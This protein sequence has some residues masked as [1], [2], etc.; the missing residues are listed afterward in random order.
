M[1]KKP[2]YR[3]LTDRVKSDRRLLEYLISYLSHT[4][5]VDIPAWDI[6]MKEELSLP[7]KRAPQ[8]ARRRLKRAA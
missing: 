7:K 5:A 6:F 3:Q 8:T 4:G 1:K 2:T